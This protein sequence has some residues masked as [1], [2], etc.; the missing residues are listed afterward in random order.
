V[1]LT[2]RSA[3]ALAAAI[4]VGELSPVEVLEAFIA[5]IEQLNPE[6]N[7]IVATRFDEARAEAAEA[8][9]AV[10]AGGP[11][12]PLHGVPAT[13][14]EAIAV[15]GMP[16]TNGSL[17]T[18][19]VVAT[20]DAA[21]VANLRAA[22]AIIMGV[23]NVPEFCGYYDTDNLVYGR[24]RS[25]HDPD[26]TSGGSSG[27]ESAALAAGLS[28]LGIGTD[29]GSSI[30]QPACWTGVYGLKPTRG[31]VP[32]AGHAG[33]GAP[34]SV[35]LFAAIGPM[36]R[37]AG[38]MAT[39]LA[40]LAGQPLAPELSGHRRVAVF[41]DDGLQPVARAC[42][43]AVRRAAA[44][45]ADN[46][47]DVVDAVP[48]AAADV[49]RCYDLMLVTEASQL[50][51]QQV[52]DRV[53]ELSPYGRNLYDGIA[54][55]TPDLETYVRAASRLA[56]LQDDVDRWLE[57]H[58]IVVCPVT[59]VPPFVASRGI[60]DVDGEEL[61]PGGKLTL[62]TWANA[63]GLPAVSVP[64]GRDASGLPLGVQVVG[65]RGRDADVIGVACE[66]EP[67]LGGWVRPR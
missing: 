66:L 40:A 54:S 21:A 48:P 56:D 58:P 5:R 6:L 59:P 31:L 7:A 39:A 42:R 38:D 55:F 9:R 61:R 26:R 41:E 15:A 1:S 24:T 51:P 52:G 14:K 49:R 2:E 35:Q 32:Q 46:G 3:C 11:L 16:Q 37:Y 34:P 17:L 63:L 47:R 44:A 45:L 8:E 67:A 60:T 65:R 25:P 64:A 12:P 50:V 20:E 57:D 30:R 53:G 22:G 36:T 10:A 27:G 13:V 33:Y 19:D 28:P 4:R 43:D 18:A 29:I 62:A 23:T